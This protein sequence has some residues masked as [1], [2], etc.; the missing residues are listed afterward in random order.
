MIA[1][2][3]QVKIVEVSKLFRRNAEQY[4]N[5]VNR[6]YRLQLSAQKQPPDF[7]IFQQCIAGVGHGQLA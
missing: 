5:L 6:P 3:C 1:G 7:R 4:L 2:G